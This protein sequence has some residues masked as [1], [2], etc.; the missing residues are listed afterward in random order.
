MQKWSGSALNTQLAEYYYR[1][2]IHPE[3]FTCSHQSFC[4]KFAYEGKITESKMSLVG[5]RYG[6]QYPRIVVLSLDPPL[7]AEGEFVEPYQ[8]T[9]EY[10]T[11]THETDN[12]SSNRPNVH[13]AM[14]QIIVKDILRL[15]AYPEKADVAV[16][17][18][19]YANRSIEN[20]TQYFAHVNAAKCSMNKPD[21]GQAD[22]KVHN[23]CS[24]AYLI[25]EL[26]ILKPEILV[27]QGKSANTLLGKLLGVVDFEDGMPQAYQKQF[28]GLPMIWL[29]MLHPARN[30]SPIRQ[31][32]PYYIQSINGWMEISNE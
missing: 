7:G 19:S 24:Q 18:E 1:Q 21:K 6:K 17:I 15:F 2:H 26:S 31:H 11:A 32:W 23:R 12:F 4:E 20:V 22:P 30:L 28:A 5:S 3:K 27:S 13:W 14:T 10:I 25:E 8:R 29:P 16:V 9:T